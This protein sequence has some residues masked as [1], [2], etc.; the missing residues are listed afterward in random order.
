MAQQPK[1]VYMLLQVD[2]E[3][4]QLDTCVLLTSELH[5][6]L[7]PAWVAVLHCETV[8]LRRAN[9]K[10]HASL[11]DERG[12][13]KFPFDLIRSIL[14]QADTFGTDADAIYMKGESSCSQ[15]RAN[16]QQLQLSCKCA[17]RRLHKPHY[18]NVSP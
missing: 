14:Q 16:A 8:E 4:T 7:P 5:I 9:G 13:S 17:C 12:C 11:F 2:G 18:P 1:I 3:E 15:T 10:Y 6:Q